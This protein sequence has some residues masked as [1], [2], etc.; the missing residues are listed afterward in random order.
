LGLQSTFNFVVPFISATDFRYNQVAVA[1]ALN[2]DGWLT[3]WLMNPLTYPPNTPP[4]QQIVIM[5][6]GGSDFSYRLPIS[7]GFSQGIGSDPHDN[8]ECG[9]VDNKDASMFSGHSVA[10]PTSH[11]K[12]S[13]FYDRYRFV[14]IL[15]S[16]NRNSPKLK[17]PIE[18]DGKVKNMVSY[19]YRQQY[20]PQPEQAIGLTPVPNLNGVPMSSFLNAK[21]TRSGKL[22]RLTKGDPQLYYCCP[23]TYVKFD[24]EF[25][26]VPPAGFG[27]D[28]VVHWYPPGAPLDTK[29]K[30][31]GMNAN[32][33]QFADDGENLSTARLSYNPSFYARGP[34]KVSAV[35]PFCLPTTLLPLY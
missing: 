31:V 29:E 22:L 15:Y 21:A 13:F 28:Y 2:S 19:F 30:M 33:T 12:C 24:L 26:V 27:S 6:S 17:N 10:L 20:Q 14:G 16:T 11:T 9:Q 32:G 34:S 4:T 3:V 18:D 23:F 25:T 5:L 1:T 8:M 7:P 35:V